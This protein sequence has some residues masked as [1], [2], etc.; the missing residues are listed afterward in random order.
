MSIIIASGE[1][2]SKSPLNTSKSKQLFSFPKTERFREY[3]DKG[4]L[5]FNLVV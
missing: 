5:F 2:I 3:H 4:L 1:Q